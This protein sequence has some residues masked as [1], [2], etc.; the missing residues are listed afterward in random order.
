MLVTGLSNT[1][2]C[3]FSPAHLVA[4]ASQFQVK[5][6][7]LPVQILNPVISWLRITK[8]SFNLDVAIAGRVLILALTLSHNIWVVGGENPHVPRENMRK[9]Y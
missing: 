6:A 2:A 3:E 1:K 4:P 5:S 9:A 7:Q 8:A